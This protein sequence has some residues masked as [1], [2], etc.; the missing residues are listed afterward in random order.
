MAHACRAAAPPTL[1]GSVGWRLRAFRSASVRSP[2]GQA[3]G[4]V[5]PVLAAQFFVK[6]V[7]DDVEALV[8]GI[9]R[10]GKLPLFSSHLREDLAEREALAIPVVSELPI[11]GIHRCFI[12]EC[13]AREFIRTKP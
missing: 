8:E 12:F 7:L 4:L 13:S 2:R 3:L 9:E 6:V 5:P 10:A 1:S 11:C